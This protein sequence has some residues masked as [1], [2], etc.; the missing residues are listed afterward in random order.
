MK[1]YL[2]GGAVR[3]KLLGRPVH[4]RDWV[5]VGADEPHMRELGFTPVGKD[6]P[7]FLHPD[8]GDEYALARTER[9]SGHGYGGFTV[10]ASSDVTLEQDLLRRDLTINA[11]AESD[12][13]ELVDPY[14]GRADLEARLL[15]HVS[16]AFAED[17]LRILRVARF[18]ARYH[19]LGFTIADE[20]MALMRQMVNQGEVQHLV[21]E[22]VWKEVSRAL[23]EPDPDVFFRVLRD[24]GALKILLP[25]LE[26]LFGVPQPA[27]H[28]PEIDTGE[29]VM[30][31]LRA[32]PPQLPVR[33][34]V[35][36]HDLGKGVT[37]EEI[38]PSHRGHERAGLPLVR[39]VCRRWRAP[40]EL[41]A[42]ATGVCEYHLHCHKAFELRP[43]TLMKLLRALDALRRPERFEQF[44]LAC[45]SDARGRKGLQDRPYPQVDYLRAVREAA[46]G[47][48]PKELME[49]GYEGAALGKAL[50]RARVRAIAK[51]K[52]SY[53]NA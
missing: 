11:M 13:G 42:L 45:E 19:H 38:L 32:A 21:A 29:H 27:I 9:K 46:C 17:P 30:L 8:T 41:T 16:P 23:T 51:V 25:E 15:R 14:G 50:D 20:T 37:P 4:E 44:L 34:A 48:S 18:K 26:R 24:C 12:Q 47:V 2:V 6:F 49:Q 35:L 52:E 22:R 40:K 5:V 31:A 28:H 10:H 1:I 3:D 36:L 33:F 7:V 53:P 39:E 43:Q